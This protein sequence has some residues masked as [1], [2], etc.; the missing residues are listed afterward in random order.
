MSEWVEWHKGYAPG[1]PLTRRLEIVQGLIRGALDAA[2]PGPIAVISMCAGDG[3]DLLGVLAGHPRRDD[4]RARLVELDPELAARAHERAALVSPAIDVVTGDAAWTSSYA[5]AVP[6]DIV[7]ACGIFGNITDDAVR[8]TVTRLPA[9]CAPNA[10]VIW[11]RGT[12]APD[13]TPTIRAWFME[14]GFSEVDFVTIPGTTL[15]VGAD[16]LMSPPP[17]FEPG[18]RLFTFLERE[19]RPSAASGH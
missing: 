8:N 1:S 10:T 2:P 16:R 13:L 6:A 11:T 15:G 18:L 5:G 19:C 7:L 3:R 14:A 17:A 4:V 12:F 9:L